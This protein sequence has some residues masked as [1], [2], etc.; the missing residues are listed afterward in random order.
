[1][2]FI[3]DKKFL[4]TA[5]ILA[6]LTVAMCLTVRILFSL[7]FFYEQTV[8]KKV[9]TFA[10]LVLVLLV[11]VVFA[12][13]I[14]ILP[15]ISSY[16]KWKNFLYIVFIFVIILVT[17]YYS[18]NHYWSVPEKHDVEICF[19]A[20][21]GIQSLEILKI[22]EPKTF[23]LYSPKSFGFDY[24]PIVVESGKCIKGEVITLYSDFSLQF[25]LR[26]MNLVVQED[27]PDGRLYLTVNKVPAVV[28]FDKTADPPFGNEIQFNDGF[29]QGRIL[30]FARNKYIYTGGKTICLLSSAFYLAL[31]FFGLTE[32]ITTYTNESNQ[33]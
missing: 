18:A 25:L 2:T 14:L 6:T 13:K 8:N 31:F 9:I 30:P 11:L 16:L 19:D 12:N 7:P 28:Y 22:E 20:I 15:Y 32:K 10:L 17:S 27:P 3:K 29:D 21:D 23:R 4:T 33:I 5:F 24:Y 1:M 26:N